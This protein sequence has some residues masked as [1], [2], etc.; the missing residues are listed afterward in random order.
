MLKSD[1]VAPATVTV[2]VADAA[3]GFGLAIGEF[4]YAV[5]EINVPLVTPAFTFTTNVNVAVAP[6]AKVPV[7][8]AM[9][10]VNVGA[11]GTEQL[12]SAGALIETNVVFVGTVSYRP[13]GAAAAGP[14]FFITIV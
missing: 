14:L 5:L 11:P 1:C 7:V 10:P 13:F 3:V 9:F 2:A 6:F 8:H 4:A 12:Q